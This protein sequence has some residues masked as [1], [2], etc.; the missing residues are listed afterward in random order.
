MTR[1]S[2]PLGLAPSGALEFRYSGP[3]GHTQ[4]PAGDRV[5]KH[6]CRV[7]PLLFLALQCPSCQALALAIYHIKTKAKKAP[8]E[9]RGT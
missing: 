2:A 3:P 4:G 7:V 5:A 6:R 8:H 9:T 1:G